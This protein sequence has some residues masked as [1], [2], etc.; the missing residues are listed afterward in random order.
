MA[1][2][3]Q[4]KESYEHSFLNFIA[5]SARAEADARELMHRASTETE[6]ARAEYLIRKAIAEQKHWRGYLNWARGGGEVDEK[7]AAAVIRAAAPRAYRDDTN[8][9]DE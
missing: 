8:D 6:K 1:A 9:N 5:E 4:R 2:R 3:A 7:Q